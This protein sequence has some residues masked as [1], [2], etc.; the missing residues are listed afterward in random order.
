[1]RFLLDH[2]AALRADRRDAASFVALLLDNALQI[3]L[4]AVLVRHLVLDEFVKATCAA[5]LLSLAHQHL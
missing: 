3:F 2:G 4:M 1:M 5:L